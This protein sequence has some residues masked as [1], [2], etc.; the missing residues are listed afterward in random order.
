[1]NIDI[2]ALIMARG[3][4][5][6]VPNKNIRKFADSSL[7]E[8]KIG[9]L[10]KIENLNGIYVNS[11]ADDILQIAQA[12]GATTVKRDPYYATNEV[13]INEVYKNLAESVPHKHILFCHLTSP[14]AREGSLRE[15]VKIYEDLPAEFD[16]LATVHTV[17][18][19]TWYKKKPV[20]YDPKKMPRSQD[21]PDYYALNFAYNIIPRDLMIRYE[22]II[23]QSFYPYHL[24]EIECFDVDTE[25]Q[26]KVAEYIYRL[27]KEQ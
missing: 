3:G 2:C 27:Y 9:Q 21:L 5:Q 4:S 17:Q 6:R 7:L 1:M 12:A 20:N 15:C 26:F 8:I 10:R 22:N 25:L 14:L 18:K 24:D 11:E 23:G 13:P 19:F 16:S